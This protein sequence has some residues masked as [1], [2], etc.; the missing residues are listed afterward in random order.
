M[1]QPKFTLLSRCLA[2]RPAERLLLIQPGALGDS[3]LTLP[4]A[5]QLSKALP[6]LAIE[7]LGHLD[8]ISLF[9][10]HRAITATADIDTAPLHLLFA[11]PPAELPP[12]FADFLAR[13]DAV[14]TWLGEPHSSFACN[15]SAAIAGPVI[16]IDRG[17]PPDH[18]HHVVHYWL[19]ELFENPPPQHQWDYQ[20]RLSQADISAAARKLHPRLGW[21]LDR[22]DYLV[23]HPG[24]GSPQKTWPASCFAQLASRIAEKSNYRVVYL[25]GPAEAERFDARSISLLNS[26]GQVLPDLDIPQACALI[27]HSL[28][29]LG[30]DSGPTHLAAALSARTLAIF[31]P[32]NPT[33]WQPLGPNVKVIHSGLEGQ[34]APSLE[35]ITPDRLYNALQNTL[36]F[37][38]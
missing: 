35:A 5:D 7:M 1:S 26:T 8:Y 17:P 36:K 27:S 34:L 4:V 23:F 13:F 22:T 2:E 10:R 31:G 3:L 6:G 20:L 28:A 18:P 32:S 15:L 24:A 11:D 33:H 25:L 30:H 16:C 29:F 12:A 38:A 14:V 37:Y 21:P 19:S 9:T